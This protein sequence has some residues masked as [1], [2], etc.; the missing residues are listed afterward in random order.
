[1]SE[2]FPIPTRKPDFYLST[3]SFGGPPVHKCWAIKPVTMEYSI[4]TGEIKTLQGCA[5][6]RVEPPLKVTS[7]NKSP[8]ATGEVIVACPM[9]SDGKIYDNVYLAQSYGVQIQYCF[10]AVPKF[11]ERGAF[12]KGEVCWCDHG[13]LCPTYELAFDP[14][15][16]TQRL[17]EASA[18]YKIRKR[19]SQA[20][21]WLRKKAKS[22]F[23]G[24]TS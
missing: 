7:L 5:L 6:L 2:A 10:P 15:A 18:L 11:E 8:Y 22:L 20:T 16:E 17:L 3:N 1:M 13:S 23:K 9:D 19:V 12:R 14:I 4:Y 21:Q 24:K